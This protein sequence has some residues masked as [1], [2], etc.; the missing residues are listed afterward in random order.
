MYKQYDG[1]PT[2]LGQELADWLANMRIVNGIRCGAEDCAVGRMAN[3]MDCLAAQLVAHFKTEVGGV[4]LLPPGTR[5]AGEEFIY[6]ISKNGTGLKLKCEAGAVTYFGLP[7]TKQDNMKCLFFGPPKDFDGAQIQERFAAMDAPPND[8]LE[9]LKLP[10][11]NPP[12]PEIGPQTQ[13][14]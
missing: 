3:G 6:T 10:T 4:Y 14:S 13:S 11:S 5:G 1:Y 9:S 7:G 2:G 12:R 8:F